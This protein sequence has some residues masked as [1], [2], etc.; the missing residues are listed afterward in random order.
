MRPTEPKSSTTRT[1]I[2][3]A[4]HQLSPPRRPCTPPTEGHQSPLPRPV[5][6]LEITGRRISLITLPTKEVAKKNIYARGKNTRA[7]LLHKIPHAAAPDR[8]VALLINRGTHPRRRWVPI[9]RA[10]DNSQLHAQLTAPSPHSSRLE[11]ALDLEMPDPP[12]DT[13]RQAHSSKLASSE[14]ASGE[15]P[16][17]LPCAPL[18]T[19][20]ANRPETPARQNFP[21]ITFKI[22]RSEMRPNATRCC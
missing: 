22:F 19:K 1:L 10:Q 9:R 6:P 15:L 13:S 3:P 12:P 11:L 14:L 8:A 17:S 2:A 20:E 7:A 21:D 5:P 18:P 4:D 16:L